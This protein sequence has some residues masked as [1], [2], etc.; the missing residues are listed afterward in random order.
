MIKIY[1]GH[2]LL[3]FDRE[4]VGLSP[5]VEIAHEVLLR[6][7][8]RLRGWI[9][10]DRDGL[11]LLRHVSESASAWGRLGRDEGDLYRGARLE[12]AL[13]WQAEHPEDLN[14]LEREFLTVSR[15]LRDADQRAEQERIRQNR[16]LRVALTIVA[17]ALAGAI[18]AGVLAFDQ[19]GEANEQ[20]ERAELEAARA[21]EEA[22]RANQESERAS[23]EAERANEQAALAEEQAERANQESE[24]AN[25]QA[26]LAEE[27]G[28]RSA[29]RRVSRARYRRSAPA[30]KAV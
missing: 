3:S 10:E 15:E 26:A 27:Q 20:A 24:R 12:Q 14:P 19:R 28:E 7:W 11:R 5:T 1:G 8:P 25:E 22:T 2:R 21:G 30:A 9:D 16:R 6:E 18:V 13:A 29:D 4:P 17:L 23:T